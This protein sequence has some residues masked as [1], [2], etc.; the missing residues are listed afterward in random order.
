MQTIVVKSKVMEL[1][2]KCHAL[3]NGSFCSGCLRGA[4]SLDRLF[5]AQHITL[6]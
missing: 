6:L 4:Q 3:L 5:M 1:R 2:I